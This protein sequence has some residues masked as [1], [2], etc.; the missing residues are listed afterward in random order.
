MDRAIYLAMNG[1]TQTMRAQTQ[2]AHNLANVS[3][4]GFRA[5]MASLDRLPVVGDGLPSRVNV[6][7]RA[8]GADFSI[9]PQMSTGRELDVSIQGQGWIA[10][11]GRDGSEGYTRA[12]DLEVN[13]DGLL[14]TATGLPVLGDAGPL[15]VPPFTKLDIGQ[16]GTVSVVPQGQGPETVASIGRIKLVNPQPT[17]MLRSGDGLMRMADGSQ[18]PADAAVTVIS[19]VLEG[20]NVNPT[21][22][23]MEVISLSRQFE[24]QIR[25]IQTADDNA[26][27]ATRL[28][29]V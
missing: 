24:M 16:D 13:A 10:V 27:A 25:A 3:T 2:A 7:E 22:A 1:A 26:E 23:L 9:G 14:V 6:I 29:R 5:E 28:L 11:Q 4:V 17:D 15:S 8:R 19:G 18:A 21:R 12:G 20:S